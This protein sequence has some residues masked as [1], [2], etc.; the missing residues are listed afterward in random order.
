MKCIYEDN[1]KLNVLYI[2]EYAKNSSLD[3]IVGLVS[4]IF[5]HQKFAI[6]KLWLSFKYQFDLGG[7]ERGWP[8][9]TH[10]THFVLPRVHFCLW[11]S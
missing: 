9:K 1:H 11:K 3:E 2:F 5:F 10:A 7:G 8:A 4:Q 6:F